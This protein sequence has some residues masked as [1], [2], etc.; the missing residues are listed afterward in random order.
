MSISFYIWRDNVVTS[1]L[2]LADRE[3]QQLAW[4]GEIASSD[5][6]PS[7]ML[8]ALWHDFAFESFASDNAGHLTTEQVDLC[9]A[10]SGSIS[11]FFQH[12][13]S[14]LGLERN[15]AAENSWQQVV[16]HSQSL[17]HALCPGQPRV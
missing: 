3:Y 9:N 15:D 1:L 11:A 10:L 16:L 14:W 12:H 5:G 8:S 7:E 4:R 13:S 17:Y 2:G 6:D